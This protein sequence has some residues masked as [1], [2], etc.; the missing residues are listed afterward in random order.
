MLYI[1]MTAFI[2]FTHLKMVKYFLERLAK[3]LSGISVIGS[4]PRAALL[5]LFTPPGTPKI[6]VSF[7]VHGTSLYNN[8]LIRI[9]IN[10]FNVQ[11]GIIIFLLYRY[12]T[13]NNLVARIHLH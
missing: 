10:I 13:L 8:K 1:K 9:K 12:S 6:I 7:R 4:Q 2:I 5:N 3:T 11:P